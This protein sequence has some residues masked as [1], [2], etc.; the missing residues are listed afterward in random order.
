MD[1]IDIV[2][3]AELNEVDSKLDSL[4]SKFTVLSNA[5]ESISQNKSYSNLAKDLEKAN[6]ALSKTPKTNGITKAVQESKKS[7]NEYVEE[8]KAK[9]SEEFTPTI[10]F[11][12]KSLEELERY[13]RDFE[14][15]METASRNLERIKLTGFESQTKGVQRYVAQLLEA[16]KSL[17]R[18]NELKESK[19]TLKDVKSFYETEEFLNSESQAR[20]LEDYANKYNE[21]LKAFTEYDNYSTA[22]F[23]DNIDWFENIKAEYPEAKD[24]VSKYQDLFENF[25]RMV[26]EENTVI[27][28]PYNAPTQ[29][30][31]SITETVESVSKLDKILSNVRPM[32]LDTSNVYA[33]NKAITELETRLETLLNKQE[34]FDENGVSNESQ[35]YV[36]LSVEIEKCYLT[37]EKYESEIDRIRSNNLL[38]LKVPPIDSSGIDKVESKTKAIKEGLKNLKI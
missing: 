12:A 18:I 6:Q 36:D 24:L 26:E 9:M 10:K 17:A 7:F 37:L 15:Q 14:K 19:S 21:L 16:E 35:K 31:E 22:T 34:K 30:T 38:E 32:E 13:G 8:V 3:N 25:Q 2:L 1:T 28:S 23:T 5:L 27:N 4:I 33:F 29:F 20:S 11:E